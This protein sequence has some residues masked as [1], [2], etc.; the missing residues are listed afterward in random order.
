MMMVQEILPDLTSA[1]QFLAMRIIATSVP[2]CRDFL[3]K[4]FSK[5]Y[6]FYFNVLVNFFASQ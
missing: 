3:E 5:I 2:I 4:T 1:T 6:S